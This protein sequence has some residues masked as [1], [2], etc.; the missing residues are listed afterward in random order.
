MRG[1]DFKTWLTQGTYPRLLGPVLL[2]IVAAT[3]VR[4]HALVTTETQE[5]LQRAEVEVGR[6][7]Q[8]LGPMLALRQ[9]E[10]PQAQAELLREASWSLQPQVQELL[11]QVP[12]EAPVRWAAEPL[13]AQAPAWFLELASIEAPRRHLAQLLPDGRTARLT[14]ALQ[15]GPVVDPVWRTVVVQAR[16]T[17]LNVALI[18]LLLVLLLRANARLLKRLRDAADQFRQGRLDARMPVQGT[19]E[20]QAVARTFNDMAG[21]VQSLVLSLHDTQRQ[22]SE[23]LHLT[24]ELIDALPWPLVLRGAD[25]EVQA[26]NKAWHRLMETAGSAAER[27]V[28]LQSVRSHLDPSDPVELQLPGQAPRYMA[29]HHAPLRAVEG[30]PAG[31]LCTIHDITPQ[32]QA[33]A[34]ADTLSQHLNVWWEHGS[35]ALLALDAHGQVLRTNP[36]AAALWPPPDTSLAGRPLCE[37]LGPAEL[38]QRMLEQIAHPALGT[39]TDAMDGL[40]LRQPAAEPVQPQRLTAR[41][42]PTV[43]GD[44]PERGWLLLRPAA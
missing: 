36:A 24:R 20:V 14:V 41:W 38:V 6:I 26:T 34:L 12:G 9:T 22:Q 40:A 7:A 17:A 13:A 8:T 37:L 43:A 42:L 27:I 15:P 19:L 35:D 3:V 10:G 28:A 18:L 5:A 31:T 16:I 39:A 11:W 25:G 4:Y 30:T 44:A 33:Q 1:I 23:Q 29:C 32:V 21:K 2:I